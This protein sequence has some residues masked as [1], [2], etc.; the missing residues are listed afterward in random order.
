MIFSADE[1]FIYLVNR[2]SPIVVALDGKLCY[3]MMGMLGLNPTT[4]QPGYVILHFKVHSCTID[5]H[6]YRI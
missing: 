5:R 4:Q 2:Y 1:S 6:I 3:G